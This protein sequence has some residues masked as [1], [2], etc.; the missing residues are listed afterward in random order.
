[1]CECSEY[2][3]SK[4]RTYVKVTN[5]NP[6]VNVEKDKQTTAI[7]RSFSGNKVFH[8]FWYHFFHTRTEILLYMLHV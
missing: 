8:S 6:P 7:R 1:M 5:I 2:Y 3:N 4:T